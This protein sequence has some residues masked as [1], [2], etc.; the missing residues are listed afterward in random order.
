MPPA[1]AIVGAGIGGLAAALACLRRGIDVEIYEQAP[2]LRELGAGVQISAN[3]TRVLYA[4]GLKEALEKV[5]VLPSG[6]AIRLWNTGQSWKIF[7]FGL[8][9]VERYGFPY[10]TLHRGDLHGV[11]ARALERAKTGAIHLGRQ[12]V[13]L[14]QSPD[15]VELRFADGAAVTAKLV[16][17]ADGLHSVLRADLFG[18]P[19]P[20]F[21]GI[22]AWRGVVP[23]DRLPASIARNLGTNWIGPGGHVVHYPLRA[24][25]LMNFVGVRERSDWTVEG[26]NLRGTTQEA[27]EDF[28]GWHPDVHALI[29][30]IDVPYKWALALRPT[31]DAWSKGRCTLLGDACHPMVPFLAQ[32]AVMALEDALVLARCLE[33]YPS[34]HATAFSRYEAARRERANK[35]VAGSAAN[36]AR[37][38]NHATADAAAA[39]A[40]VAHEFQDDRVR[41]RYDWLFRYDAESVGI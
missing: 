36:I 1:I 19:K 35:V 2:E 30:N 33:K 17:G 22:V 27:L 10:L 28:S 3:G 11:L 38:H 15:Q 21:C 31:M 37:F 40:Y 29:R 16:I 39:Q 6:K 18:A 8:E 25:T 14:T 32:G 13:G 41:E 9:S 23:M 26:W 20:Q 34:D 7:D 5:Q 4:L 12:C 24:G